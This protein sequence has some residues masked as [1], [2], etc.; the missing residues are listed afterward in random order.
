MKFET[1]LLL[2]YFGLNKSEKNK[3]V[4]LI[5]RDKFERI[6]K[7]ADLTGLR[8]QMMHMSPNVFL[9]SSK[10]EQY[11]IAIMQVVRHVGDLSSSNL[12]LAESIHHISGRKITRPEKRS[13]PEL[14]GILLDELIKA[15]RAKLIEMRNELINK[16][17]SDK[18]YREEGTSLE[19]WFSIILES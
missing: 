3:L 8:D 18:E 4:F 2:F 7:Q 12:D 11:D 10:K 6:F 1:K 16:I 13:K 19:R 5:G 17:A 14:Q 9:R 15:P